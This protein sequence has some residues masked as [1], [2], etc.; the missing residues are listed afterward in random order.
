M[1]DGLSVGHFES[2]AVL[3]FGQASLSAQ[4]ASIICSEL[5]NGRRPGEFLT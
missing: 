5:A 4:G 1:P 2:W 3:P